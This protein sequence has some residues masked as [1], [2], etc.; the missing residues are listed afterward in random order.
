MTKRRWLKSIIIASQE[1]QPALPFQRG[2][3]PKR[4]ALKSTAVAQSAP[5][6]A[7]AR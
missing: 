4:A 5:R 2:N 1:Q 3:R 6:A 7:C